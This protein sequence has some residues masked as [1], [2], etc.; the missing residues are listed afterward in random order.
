MLEL[1]SSRVK[2]ILIPYDRQLGISDE[3]VAK[4]QKLIAEALK[5]KNFLIRAELAEYLKNNG[6]S[7]LGQKLG[8]LLYY[9][10]Q[11]ALICSG[12]RRGKQFTYGLLEEI[13]PKAKNLNKEG[14]P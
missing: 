3:V 2:K 11:N 1:T 5:G 10:E 4:S 14:I 9:S 6:I 7:A 8:H 12:P 13:V